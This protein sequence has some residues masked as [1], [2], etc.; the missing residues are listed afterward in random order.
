METK[1]YDQSTPATP[2]PPDVWGVAFPSFLPCL[3]WTDADVYVTPCLVCPL[4]QVGSIKH[5]SPYH[6]LRRTHIH[7]Y[8]RILGSLYANYWYKIHIYVTLRPLRVL[9]GSCPLRSHFQENSFASFLMKQNQ[10][11]YASIACIELL[12]IQKRKWVEGSC[13]HWQQGS[14]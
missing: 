11:C 3:G 10:I 7:I 8:K 1:V 5:D 12:D 4:Q 2:T 13:S 6:D 9:S 14:W